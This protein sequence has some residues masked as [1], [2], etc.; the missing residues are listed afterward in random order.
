MNDRHLKQDV[1][2]ALII[3]VLVRLSYAVVSSKPYQE[4]QFLRDCGD[5]HSKEYCEN[6]WRLGNG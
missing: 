1:I 3:L 2:V 5:T 4:R 6:L